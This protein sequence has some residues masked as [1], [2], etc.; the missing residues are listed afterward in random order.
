MSALPHAHPTGP[1]AGT[2]A[3]TTAE[4][5]VLSGCHAGARA[6]VTGPLHLGSGDECD[7]IL[8][9]IALPEGMASVCLHVE[10]GRWRV[11]PAQTAGAATGAPAANDGSGA[12]SNAL[13][14]LAPWGQ[15]G[16]VGGLVLTV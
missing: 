15:V 8:S 10:Q 14:P 1:D 2:D 9:D 12:P 11:V 13:V 4:L 5:R 7:I 3:S 6:P 16:T